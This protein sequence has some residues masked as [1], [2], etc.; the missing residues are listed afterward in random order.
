MV[1]RASDEPLDLDTL[2]QQV[3][4]SGRPS[5]RLIVCQMHHAMEHNNEKE[6]RELSTDPKYIRTVFEEL[7]SQSQH[8]GRHLHVQELTDAWQAAQPALLQFEVRSVHTGWIIM[9]PCV[10]DR[11]HPQHLWRYQRHNQLCQVSVPVHSDSAW[12]HEISM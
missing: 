6:L 5:T 2:L 4:L 12:R 8:R 10:A 1:L 7:R 11:L 3:G 9:E